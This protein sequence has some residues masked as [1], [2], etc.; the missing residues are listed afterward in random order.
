MFNTYVALSFFGEQNLFKGGAI[1][2]IAAAYCQEDQNGW[3]NDSECRNYFNECLGN[4]IESS[5]TRVKYYDLGS[6][7]S[8]CTGN[9]KIGR[10]AFDP[11]SVGRLEGCNLN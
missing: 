10:D 6:A 9:G 5:Q 2:C 4:K 8:N 7:I 1:G 3:R 11:W